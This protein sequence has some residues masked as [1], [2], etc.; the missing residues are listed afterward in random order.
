[1]ACLIQCKEYYDQE[2]NTSG[3]NKLMEPKLV[4]YIS[5]LAAGNEAR[6]IA[7]IGSGGASAITLGLAVAAQQT[8]GRLVCLRSDEETLESAKKQ[9]ENF[10][11]AGATEFAVGHPC[12]AV[13]RLRNVDFAVIDPNV[14]EECMEEVFLG[15]DMNPRG[16]IVVVSNVFQSRR[17]GGRVCSYARAVRERGG[18]ESVV[19]LPI[20]DG[21]EVTRIRTRVGDVEGN[22]CNHM[23]RRPKRAFLVYDEEVHNVSCGY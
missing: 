13:G 21:L 3:S 17:L 8:G 14:L 18:V 20:G 23:C 6:V 5:A 15:I 7:D 12:D 1:M 16:S 4:E 10:G 22:G 2:T 11:L 19:V 9:I